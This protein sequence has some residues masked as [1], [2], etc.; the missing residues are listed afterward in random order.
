MILPRPSNTSSSSG[1]LVWHF[2]AGAVASLT[3][4]PLFLI[5]AIFALSVPMIGYLKASSRRVAAAIWMAAGSGWFLASTFWIAHAL[6]IDNP[7]LWFLMPLLAAAMAGG[8]A[9][10]WAVAAAFSWS[11]GQTALGR[12]FWVGRDA[13]P[14]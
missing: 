2:L 4:P 14:C 13:W 9:M 5:P 7:G 6:I 11:F 8:L 10:F 12:S 1:R 3:V